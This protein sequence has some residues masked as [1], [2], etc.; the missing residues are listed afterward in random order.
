MDNFNFQTVTLAGRRILRDSIVTGEDIIFTRFR[1][2]DSA[3]QPDVPETMEDVISP[4]FWVPVAETSKDENGEPAVQVDGVFKQDEEHSDFYFRELALFAKLGE[5]GQEVMFG[6]LHSGPVEN[7]IPTSDSTNLATYNFI[8]TIPVGSASV[9]VTYDPEA[10]V[11]LKK[12]KDLEIRVNEFEKDIN[13]EIK[14][15]RDD[16]D[17][18][19][20]EIGDSIGN[21]VKK[22]GDT[23]T[24]KLYGTSASFSGEIS[25]ENIS[26]SGKITG[27]SAEISGAFSAHS[28]T[29]TSIQSGDIDSNTC[30]ITTKLTCG[31]ADF[32]GQVISLQGFNGNLHGNVFGDEADFNGTVV[33]EN[34]TGNTSIKGGAIS[35]TTCTLSGELSGTSA[36]LSGDLSAKNVMGTKAII[37]GSISGTT[38]TFSSAVTCD[39]LLSGSITSRSDIT[40]STISALAGFGGTLHGNVF[41]EEV[42][43]SKSIKGGAI[44]GTTGTF[45]GA[46]TSSS[47][48]KGTTITATTGFKGNLTGDVTGKLNGFSVYTSYEELL[49]AIGLENTGAQAA[50][51]N[52]VAKA[53]KGYIY[54]LCYVPQS[55]AINA[56]N[57]PGLLEIKSA[58]MSGNES[59][60]YAIF[61]MYYYQGNVH[62]RA[63]RYGASSPSSWTALGQA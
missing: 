31:D 55:Y 17:K 39:T 5:G 48:I 41:G 36:T 59:N 19:I 21:Y 29:G 49:K 43:G 14:K 4:R 10:L 8:V 62:Y 44:S 7:Y 34:L 13:A 30:T 33:A 53:I 58:S 18:K 27:V 1:I 40:A 35:G 23:M 42:S 22:A 9:L 6:Y 12:Y 24:G 2:G 51:L 57:S 26:T 16:A 25:A 28:I 11:S 15:I 20:K 61:N 50:T 47:T 37:G 45:S 56:I 3:E 38:G 52:A 60:P 32:K 63:V 54:A 46:I